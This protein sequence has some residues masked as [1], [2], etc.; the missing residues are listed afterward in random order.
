VTATTLYPVYKD[1]FINPKN[2]NNNSS[3]TNNSAKEI[4]VKPKVYSTKAEKIKTILSK[5]SKEKLQEMKS[6]F[7]ELIEII[8]SLLAK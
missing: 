1:E 3:I 6:L 8:D 4:V 7:L 5:Y 2:K